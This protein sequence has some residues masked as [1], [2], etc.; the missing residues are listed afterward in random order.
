VSY[1]RRKICFD[2]VIGEPQD[3]ETLIAQISSPDIIVLMDRSIGVLR[4]IGF[5]DQ[6]GFETEEIDDEPPHEHLAT[7]YQ[8]GGFSPT[9]R[10]RE[11]PFCRCLIPPQ[12]S[13]VVPCSARHIPRGNLPAK[14]HP[15]GR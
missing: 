10:I 1:D 13:R 5:D 15:A 8:S 4:T 2:L 3:D 12:H 14:P 7:E 6:T 9:E 11:H